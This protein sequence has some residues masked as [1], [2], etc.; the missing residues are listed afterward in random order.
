[1][2]ETL[3]KGAGRQN[4]GLRREGLAYLRHHASDSAM[5]NA[6]AF[7]TALAQG[8]IGRGLH[9]S[10][11][12]LPIQGL[13]RLG[14]RCANGRPLTCVQDT[15]LN[16]GLINGAGHFPTKRVNLPHQMAFAHSSNGRIA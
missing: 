8:E 1:M 9:H 13:V 11:H 5:L 10:L 2:Y 3:E 4:N 14:A 16:A 7:H 15:E 12:P 6:E